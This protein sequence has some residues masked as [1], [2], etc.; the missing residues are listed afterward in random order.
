MIGQRQAYPA[1]VPPAA[2]R[3]ECGGEFDVLVVPGL[4][5]SGPAHWQTLWQA[6][7]PNWRRVEQQEWETSDLVAWQAAVESEI[8]VSRNPV[9]IVAHSFGCLAS[10]CAIERYSI[11]VAGALLVAPADPHKFALDSRIPDGPLA[12]RSVLIGSTN[13][14]WLSPEHALRLAKLWGA[15]YIELRSA[16]HINAESG[17]G[18]WPAGRAL[19]DALVDDIACAGA[20]TAHN[21]RAYA[22]AK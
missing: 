4:G 2:R 3:R 1:H 19:L 15:T 5:G 17:F 12:C 13:D 10:V 11:R 21:S 18:D 22:Q 16:G 14:P 8:R 7:S 6:Q 20:A 9:V